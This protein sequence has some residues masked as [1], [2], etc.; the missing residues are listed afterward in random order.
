M[1]SK[2][3]GTWLMDLNHVAKMLLILYCCIKLGPPAHS[4]SH[5]LYRIV[6][7]N[8]KGNGDI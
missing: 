7:V 2:K 4:L 6:Q 1:V 8:T 3:I 5:I